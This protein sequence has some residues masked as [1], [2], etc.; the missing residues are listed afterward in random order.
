MRKEM[1]YEEGPEGEWEVV[2]DFLPSPSLL[3]AAEK[4]VEVSIVL[5]QSTVDLYKE[6]GERF[7][8]EY[9]ELI[10][11]VVK[12]YAAKCVQLADTHR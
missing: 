2:D 3:A 9:P 4:H 5:S 1:Q 6:Q 11:R 7:H 12:A 8:E 10:R